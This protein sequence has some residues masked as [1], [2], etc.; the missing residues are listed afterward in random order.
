[1]HFFQHFF[2]L[3]IAVRKRLKGICINKE[4]IMKNS[5]NKFLKNISCFSYQNE[6]STKNNSSYLDTPFFVCCC[7]WKILLLLRIVDEISQ[8][9]NKA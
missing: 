8:N 1:M 5:K 3:H 6:F 4:K 2:F 9:L 7:I